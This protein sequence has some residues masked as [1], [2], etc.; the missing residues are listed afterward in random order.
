M[1][2]I[3]PPTPEFYIARAKVAKRMEKKC[4]A[5]GQL[6]EARAWRDLNVRYLRRAEKLLGI[7]PSDDEDLEVN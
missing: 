7:P 2:E 6:I 3:H 5:Y 4:H 1:N